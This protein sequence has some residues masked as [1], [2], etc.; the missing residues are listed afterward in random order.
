MINQ[1]LSP[2]IR[3]E[4]TLET[5]ISQQNVNRRVTFHPDSMK[6][7]KPAVTP[8]NRKVIRIPSKDGKIVI[9]FSK[10]SRD[11]KRQQIV[12]SSRD[13]TKRLA[14]QQ[15]PSHIQVHQRN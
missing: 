15:G 1:Q 10:L 6:K 11:E 4:S 12:E 14:Y 2:R 13:S 3:H 8:F 7:P 5:P 9:P